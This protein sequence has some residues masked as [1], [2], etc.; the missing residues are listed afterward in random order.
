MK[1]REITH[2]ALF[3][4]LTCAAA[5]I[6]RYVPEGLV[7]FSILPMLV[8]LAGF[9]LG[10][11]L[12]AWSMAVYALLGLVGFP[13]FATPPFGGITYFLMPTFG[14]L[15]GYIPA[16][17][18]VGKIVKFKKDPGIILS[19]VAVLAGLACIYLFGLIYMYLSLNSWLHKPMT[20]FGVVKWGFLPFIG[21]D[22]IKGAVVV[23]FSRALRKNL[24][25]AGSPVN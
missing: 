10:P 9:V 1:T 25:T 16:A 5:V 17:Y 18:A 12:G 15:L 8:L 22:L 23:I 2:T 14:F 24:A 6:F 3:T 19:A 21:L 7:P 13:V 11:R 20:V 4:A